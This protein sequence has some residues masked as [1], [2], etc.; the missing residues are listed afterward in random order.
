VA[1]VVGDWGGGAVWRVTSGAFPSNAYFCEAGVPGGGILIDPGLD[2]PAIDAELTELGLRPHQVFCTHGHFDHTGGASH[3]QQRYGCQVFLH[4]AD[5]RTV[6]S[7]NFLLM[8]LR[9]P[10]RVPA[11][12]ITLVDDDFCA[13]IAG[14]PLRFRRAPGHTP[15]SCVLEFGDAWFTGDTLYRRGLGLNHLPGED[16]DALRTTL[17]GLWPELGAARTVYP[18]HG[19]PADGETV[20]TDNHALTAFLGLVAP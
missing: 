14:E 1:T 13:D 7:S 5:A 16:Q 12:D 17:L 2:A 3:F 8:A 15:G 4:R 18:G 20:R 19:D 11:A 10:Q 6:A 9:I